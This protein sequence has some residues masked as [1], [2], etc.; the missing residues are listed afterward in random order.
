[1]AGPGLR[2]A[3]LRDPESLALRLIC[4]ALFAARFLVPAESAEE[5]ETLWIVCGWLL[6]AGCAAWLAART[7]R[8]KLRLGFPEAMLALLVLGQVLSALLAAAGDGHGRAA[9]NMLW[10]WL[11]IAIAFAMLRNVF[12]ESHGRGRICSLLLTC[13]VLLAGLGIWQRFVWYPRIAET[14]LEWERLTAEGGDPL[15]LDELRRELGPELTGLSGG[16][17]LALR[18]RVL[19]SNEPFGRFAL[20]NTLAGALACFFVLASVLVADR[21]RLSSRWTR[22]L[23]I[24]I[25]GL[26]GFSLLLTKS[27]TAW[28]GA[29]CGAIAV[30]GTLLVRDSVAGS[31]RRVL[32][33]LASISGAM[34]LVAAVAV[35]LGLIDRQVFTE[36]PKSL[37][38]RFQYWRGAWEVISEHPLLGVG[39]GN[40]RSHYL[41]HKLPGASEEISDPHNALLDVWATGGLFGLAGLLGLAALAGRRV[42][43]LARQRPEL[44]PRPSRAPPGPSQYRSWTWLAGLLGC[45]LVFVA[46]LLLQAR[47]DNQVLVLAMSCPAAAWHVASLV[48]TDQR[49]AAVQFAGMGG[50]VALSVHLSG[51]GGIAMPAV[52]LLALVC[53]FCLVRGDAAAT[54]TMPFRRRLEF[55]SPR[56]GYVC[57]AVCVLLLAACLW[58][59]LVPVTIAHFEL[60]AGDEELLVDQ[61]P[62]RAI[63]HFERAASADRLDPAPWTQLG[64]AHFALWQ[65][66]ARDAPEHFDQ[67]LAALETAIDRD[68][69]NPRAWLLLGDLW[70]RRFRRSQEQKDALQAAAAIEQAIRRYPHAADIRAMYAEALSGADE[71][72]HAREEAIRAIELDNLNQA[73]GHVDKYLPPATRRRMEQLAEPIIS[74]AETSAGMLAPDSSAFPNSIRRRA[75]S[76]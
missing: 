45:G 54:T 6:V 27:R 68:R 53:W 3:A 60:L 73:A 29:L 24:G 61:N 67:A 46:S 75:R 38:Y 25:V 51:A 4:G 56:S 37:S 28:T 19:E 32:L 50:A 65:A 33:T 23:M 55:T 31:V 70:M 10:E 18:Q 66:G 72:H 41:L 12:H 47:M 48:Q 42:W 40:F 26:I 62:R 14:Y 58:S 69:L 30:A 74:Q 13:G 64:M 22:T 7:G 1:M 76:G 52:V 8:F 35:P 44:D 36:A 16:S 57:A 71:A 17:Q 11:G 21:W 2:T 34:V 20:A 9:V 15:R 63:D 5:G 39:P 49:D 59:A 43:R